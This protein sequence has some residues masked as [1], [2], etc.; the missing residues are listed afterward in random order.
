[1]AITINHQTNDISATSGSITID[2]IAIGGG[3]GGGG[4][5]SLP[6]GGTA[7]QVLTKTSSTNYDAAWVNYGNEV[8]STITSSGGTATIDTSTATVFSHSLTE[9]TTYTFS[10]PPANNTAYGFTLKVVQSSTARTIT[11]PTTV[12]WAAATAPTLSTGSGDVDVFVFFTH[13]NGTN[14]YG[15]VG[16]QDLS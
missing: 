8:F 13:D 4:V 10:N 9:N 11:W 1:M 5:G 7:N 15:F 14:W 3:G 6:T 2:G 16:G 12:R